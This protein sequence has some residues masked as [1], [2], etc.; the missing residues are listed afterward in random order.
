MFF[1]VSLPRDTEAGVCDC[2][3]FAFDCDFPAALLLL[4]ATSEILAGSGKKI[5][6]AVEWREFFVRTLLH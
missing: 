2:V 6:S 5:D 3:P 1:V 4:G